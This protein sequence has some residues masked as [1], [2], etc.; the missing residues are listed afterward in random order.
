[1]LEPTNAPNLQPAFSNE[2]DVM[3]ISFE[4]DHASEDWQGW[5]DWILTAPPDAIKL[6]LHRR[7]VLDDGRV[8]EGEGY[9]SPAYALEQPG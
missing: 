5:R 4:I 7:A 8:E 2:R 6:L 3:T 1:M 9:G